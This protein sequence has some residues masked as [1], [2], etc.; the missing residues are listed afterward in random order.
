MICFGYAHHRP[1]SSESEL[2]PNQ[3]DAYNDLGI[4]Y[5]VQNKLA[6]ATACL[7]KC[8]DPHHFTGQK[9]LA[10]AILLQK[11]PAEAAEWFR[12]ALGQNPKDVNALN[13]LGQA[14]EDLRQ[15]AE[16][17]ECFR[18][19]I[20]IDHNHANAHNNLGNS[21]VSQETRPGIRVLSAS[22]TH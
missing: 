4:A 21:L 10:N 7:R 19:A 11:K 3:A 13:N 14:F 9:N 1:S 15:T 6:E 20:L 18:H 16:A 8:L 17:I 5:A 22:P 2:N 12:R